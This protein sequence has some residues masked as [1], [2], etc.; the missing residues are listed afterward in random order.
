MLQQFRP[1][2]HRPYCHGQQPSFLEHLKRMKLISFTSSENVD[3]ISGTH[4]GMGFEMVETKL[5]LGSGKHKETVFSGIIFRFD[6]EK[7]FPGMLVA[8]KRGNW[9]QRATREFWR[10][11]PVDELP[12]G[13][14]QLDETHE[15]HSDNFAAARPVIAGPLTSVLTWLGNK[16]GGGDVRIALSHNEGY[17]MLPAKRD[18]FSLPELT[19]DVRYE[20]D[21]EPIIREMA[22]LLAVAHVVRRVG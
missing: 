18:Y 1:Y 2:R 9:L 21:V 10:T 19:Q 20:W 3:I 8:A 14:R 5:I 4:E 7:E 15:F 11:G 6:L 17:L 12:S 16:W 22:T 13:N